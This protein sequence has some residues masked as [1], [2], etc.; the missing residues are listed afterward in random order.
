M[1][2]SD[3]WFLIGHARFRVR[4]A[5]GLSDFLASCLAARL[6]LM[7]NSISFWPAVALR[8]FLPFVAWA[9]LPM[10]RFNASIRSTTF[11]PRGLGF[12]PTV[13]PLRLALISSARAAS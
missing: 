13:L 4:A 2:Q 10:L 7:G 11:S 6:P 1:T 5:A 8:G 9:S 3:D 12:A